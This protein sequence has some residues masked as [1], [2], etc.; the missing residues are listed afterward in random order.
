MLQWDGHV[1][2][3]D[4]GPDLRMQCL[5]EQ[6]KRVDAV[7]YTHTHADHVHGIDDLR[8]YNAVA[9]A[10]IDVY[11]SEVTL[12]RLRQHFGYA[13][14]GKDGE[15]F[16]PRLEPHIVKST[17][18]LFG[19]QIIPLELQHGPGMVLGYRFGPLAYLTDCNL[20]P[21]RSW[22]LL[23]NLRV[24]IIDGLRYR[25]HASHFTIPQAIEVGRKLG[26][27]RVILT[28]LSHDVDYDVHGRDLPEGVEFAYDGL[29]LC[30]DMD[31][32][33]Y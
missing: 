16:C 18:T 3:I 14:R 27:E 4:T 19:L 6:V 10:D 25:A 32:E 21:P 20:I 23:H 11:G 1:L 22:A 2:L 5:R 26:A 17:F 30:L 24:L 15:G 8:P 12:S 7:L 31:A 9:H 28:H 33:G 29:S 13:F